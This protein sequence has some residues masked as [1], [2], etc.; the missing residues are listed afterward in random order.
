[1]KR[2]P[3]PRKN[4]VLLVA[5]VV[6]CQVAAE[7]ITVGPVPTYPFDN[8]QAGI[9][10]A[11]DGDIVVVESGTYTGYGNHDIDFQGKAIIVRSVNGPNT[12]RIDCAQE[13]R[14]VL[15]HSGE[16]A[17]SVLDGFTITNG[18]AE[19]GGGICCT[20]M[21]SPTIANCVLQENRADHGG[22]GIYLSASKPTLAECAFI[23]NRGTSYQVRDDEGTRTIRA[24][25]GA[26]LADSSF[27]TIHDC[28]FDK[29]LAMGRWGRL[30][31]GGYHLVD[32]L[33]LHR[34]RCKRRRRSV[35]QCESEHCDPRR[36]RVP[37]QSGG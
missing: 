33:Y 32:Q 25:G 14:G 18:F 4:L 29:N 8:I 13:G 21:S 3:W 28:V 24:C 34:K 19:Q 23:G 27:P 30:Q 7:T 37:E 6:A 5:L 16:Q 15:F 12:C 22:G 31:Y 10:A 9:D 35:L 1:M 11:S 2:E 36:V 17:T 20:E 26:L